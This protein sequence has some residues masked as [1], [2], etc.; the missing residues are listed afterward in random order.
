[1][2]WLDFAF[3]GASRIGR[4]LHSAFQ[5]NDTHVRLCIS[6]SR[7]NRMGRLHL[8]LHFSGTILMIDD[9][10]IVSGVDTMA[11]AFGSFISTE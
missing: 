11:G 7:G 2:A 5:Q 4:H 10:S 9:V 1:M 8:H 3:S 6:R